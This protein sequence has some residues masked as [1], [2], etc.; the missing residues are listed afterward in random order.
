MRLAV[1]I[2]AMRKKLPKPEFWEEGQQIRRSAKAIPAHIAEGYGTLSR[3][4]IDGLP[5]MPFPHAMRHRET[6]NFCMTVARFQKTPTMTEVLS[7]IFWGKNSI[8]G[9]RRLKNFEHA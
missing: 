5:G 4:C 6:S 9:L 2:D 8:I 7:T 3:F 1:E